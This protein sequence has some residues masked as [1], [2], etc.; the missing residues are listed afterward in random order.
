MTNENS[1]GFR[2]AALAF[3]CWG[4]LPLYWRLLH[5]VPSEEVL[6]HRVVWSVVFVFLIL[7]VQRRM[8]ELWEVLSDRRTLMLMMGSGLLIGFNWFLYI[9]AVNHDRVIET[10]LG[11]FM[12]PMVSILLGYIFLKEEVRGLMKPAVGFAMAGILI[13]AVGYGKFPYVAF[14]LA[15]SFGFYGLFRK[16]VHVKPLPGL[17]IEAAILMPFTLAYLGYVHAGGGGAFLSDTPKTLLLLGTGVMTSVPLLLYVAGA[18]RIRLGTLGTLQYISPTITF[19]IG[20]FVFGEPLGTGKI[21]IFVFIWIGVA[22]Y[23]MQL[24]RDTRKA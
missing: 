24:F 18:S 5:S 20:V 14:L 21:T 23:M 12:C 11:Y 15:V 16:K 4:T 9:W 19:F 6:S 17:F 22:L 10:S 1:A 8:S 2:Y 7:L 13:G 3:I